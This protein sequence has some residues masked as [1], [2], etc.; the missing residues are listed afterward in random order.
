MTLEQMAA[1]LIAQA[2]QHAVVI[3]PAD[4]RPCAAR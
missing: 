1:W 4:G 3:Q 2:Q